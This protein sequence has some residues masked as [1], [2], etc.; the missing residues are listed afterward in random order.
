MEVARRKA[1]AQDVPVRFVQGDV[2]RLADLGA[3]AEFTLLMD[4]GCYRKTTAG[5]RDAY[6]DASREW[7]L[8]KRVLFWSVQSPPGAARR[9]EGLLAGSP[10]CDL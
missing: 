10:A 8:R 2:T 5:R 4:G 9:P 1:A 3:D 6:A 7:L